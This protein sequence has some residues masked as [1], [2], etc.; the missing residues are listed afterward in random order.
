MRRLLFL[1]ALLPPGALAQLQLFEFDGTTE[2]PVSSLYQLPPAAPGDNVITRF[3]AF[4]TGVAAVTF[5]NLS[6]AGEAFQISAAP[7][8]PYVIAPGSFA[9]FKVLFSP[10]AVGGYSANLLVNT[11]AVTLRGSAVAE[12]TL[13]AG[14]T[15]LAVG[16]TADFGTVLFNTMSTE[17]FTLSNPN[18]SAVTVAQISVAGGGFKGPLGITTPLTLSPGQAA[19]FQIVFAPTAGATYTGTLTIDQRTFNLKGLGL[20]P[21]LPAALMVFPATSVSSGTQTSV[22][23]QL[24]SAAQIAGSGTLSMVFEPSVAGVKDDPAIQFLTG[25]PRA[26]T[27]TVAAGSTVGMFG[28]ESSLSFQTGST[29]GTIVFTLQ[30]GNRTQTASLTIAPAQVYLD[31]TTGEL[32][33]GSV[34]VGLVGYD[35]T[36]SASQLQFTFFD[37]TGKALPPGLISVDVTQDFKSYFATTVAGGSFQLRAQFLV[38]GDSVVLGSVN[39]YITNSVGVTSVTGIQLSG[40]S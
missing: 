36:Y 38:S 16:G 15:A 18:Q 19:S 37:T 22:S 3:R 7:S 4:N 12:P 33:A 10:D 11:I 39:V 29:A 2:A 20:D 35:N 17:S 32:E 30:W 34:I 21:P 9:E 25:P 14:T 26:A 31:T 6:I 8:L 28:S 1:F 5:Q 27:V 23:I 40:T 13:A 24:A